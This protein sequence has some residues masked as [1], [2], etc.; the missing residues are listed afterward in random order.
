MRLG[1]ERVKPHF[2]ATQLASYY[3]LPVGVT[4]EREMERQERKTGMSPSFFVFM[5]VRLQAVAVGCELQL[6]AIVEQPCHAHSEHL[7]RLSRALDTLE[8]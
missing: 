5:S 8:V 3:I 4:R 7:Y 6:L 2:L 1:L